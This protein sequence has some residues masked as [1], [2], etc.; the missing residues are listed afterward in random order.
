MKRKDAKTPLTAEM[1]ADPDEVESFDPANGPC[2]T[3]ADFRPD[4]ASKPSSLWNKSIIEVFVDKGRYSGTAVFFPTSPLN[5]L[6]LRVENIPETARVSVGVYEL[7]SV[8][9][10]DDSSAAVR[11]RDEV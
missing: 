10:Q 8:W 1:S 5:V 7:E 11:A 4:L 6:T 3:S 2:C 9:S